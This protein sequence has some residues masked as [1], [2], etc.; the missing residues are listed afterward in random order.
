MHY[1]QCY[2]NPD[3]DVR[4]GIIGIDSKILFLVLHSDTKNRAL[5]EI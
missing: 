2:I 5:R 4:F 1:A 3:R